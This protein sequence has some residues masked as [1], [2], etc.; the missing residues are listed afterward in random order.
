MG[1][2]DNS[3]EPLTWDRQLSL[4]SWVWATHRWCVCVIHIKPFFLLVD[5][6][7]TQSVSALILRPREIQPLWS[8]NY[9]TGSYVIN[10]TMQCH[11][12]HT[13]A[14]YPDTVL[15]FSFFFFFPS[16]VLSS[17]FSSLSL[18]YT[19]SRNSDL[20]SHSRLFSPTP[21]GSCLAFFCREMI[22]AL[23]S[24]VDVLKALVHWATGEGWTYRQPKLPTSHL[25][26]AVVLSVVYLL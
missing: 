17:P 11:N 8:Q 19:C 13:P 20:G 4:Q 1:S 3:A 12:I 24:L 10:S 22:S 7:H 23:Y 18:L 9:D 6:Q 2:L 15:F 26:F 21:Y 5:F 25:R 14:T 16:H